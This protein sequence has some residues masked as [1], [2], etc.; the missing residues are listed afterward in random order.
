MFSS[1]STRISNYKGVSAYTLQTSVEFL[2]YAY[3]ATDFWFFFTRGGREGSAVVLYY[4]TCGTRSSRCL[5]DGNGV[6]WARKKG[7]G[8]HDNSSDTTNENYAPNIGYTRACTHTHTTVVNDD[9]VII[10][11]RQTYNLYNMRN[12]YIVLNACVAC[13]LKTRMCAHVLFFCN[14]INDIIFCFVLFILLQEFG[15][16][17]QKRLRRT[18]VQEDN[19]VG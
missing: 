1:F 12:I 6:L 17:R 13:L 14:T 8:E 11:R 7:G 15:G 4:I 5:S 16:P 3:G 9:G 2:K 19:G 10:F 18:R